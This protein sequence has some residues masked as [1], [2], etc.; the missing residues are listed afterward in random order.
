MKNT[1]MNSL[2]RF[3]Y[4]AAMAVLTI[5]LTAHFLFLMNE[6]GWIR[7]QL[8]EWMQGWLVL[9]PLIWLIPLAWMLILR[10]LVGFTSISPLLITSVPPLIM[11][12]GRG[13]LNLLQKTWFNYTASWIF[14][15]IQLI[16]FAMLW[17]HILIS[18]KPKTE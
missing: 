5:N 6:A 18:N 7:L 16:L 3:Q 12:I 1:I 14:A 10:S 13:I 11:L 8:Y 4:F 17:R 2:I 15:V 9:Y